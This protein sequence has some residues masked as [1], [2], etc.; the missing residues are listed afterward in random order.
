[1]SLNVRSFGWGQGQL[2]WAYVS[3]RLCQAL[4]NLGNNVYPISTNG[5][6]DSD[7]FFNKAK[8][9]DSVVNLQKFGPGKKAIDIDFCYTVPPNFPQR[10]LSNSKYKCAIYNYE[11]TNMPRHWR[12]FYGLVDFYFPSSDFSAEVF[13]RNDVPPEKVFVIPHGVDISVFNKNIPAIKLNTKK[14]FKFVSVV[15][16]HYRKN[17][18]LLLNAYCQAFNKDDDVCLVLKTKVY[19]HSDGKHH[20]QNN[21]GG[22]KAFEIIL[23]DVFKNLAE[24]YGNNMPEIELLSGHVDNVS[25]IY[26]ACDCH[27]TTTG[28]EG[29]FMPGL[30]SMAC[31]LLNIAPNYSGHLTYMNESNA[32]LIDT[33][34]RLAKQGE[35]YWAFN[36]RSEI[37]QPNLKH[38]I[39]LMR[40]AVTEYDDL[41]E[42]FGPEMKAT[43]DKFSWEYAAQ[44]IVDAVEGRY[45]HYIPGTYDV[46]PR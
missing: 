19:K 24:K 6:K 16:P 1:M 38:T 20:E 36:S 22:R 41:M 4:E 31:G 11:T 32:L 35:Q 3:A 37:G 25:S 30:E 8:M 46:W 2:S 28:A 33:K 26:N 10:F 12:K 17:I 39:D 29:W 18:D 7:P 43:V 9:L 34:L 13:V 15:A 44:L 5:I 21:P 23:G 40:K 14:K 45:A 42:K 27:V